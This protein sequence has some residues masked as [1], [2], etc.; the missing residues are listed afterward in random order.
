[1]VVVITNAITLLEAMSVPVMK[2][3]FSTAM[4]EHALVGFTKHVA[5]C[6]VE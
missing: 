2:D 4:A 6:T 5:T 3:I 1:M